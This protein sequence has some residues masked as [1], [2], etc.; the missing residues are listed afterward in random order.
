VPVE[1]MRCVLLAE[2]KAGS[3][4]SF[5]RNL[6]G[7]LDQSLPHDDAGDHGC[8]DH[9]LK[10]AALAERAIMPCRCSS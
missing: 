2:G 10:A 7:C 8:R 1:L 5:S 6:R 3:G 4:R 9:T